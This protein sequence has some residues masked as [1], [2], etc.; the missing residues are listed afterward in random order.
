[1]DVFIPNGTGP[2]WE[3]ELRFA[4]RSLHRYAQVDRVFVF[5]WKPWWLVDVEFVPFPDQGGPANRNTLAK[6]AGAVFHTDIGPQFIHTH[7]DIFLLNDFDPLALHHLPASYARSDVHA[8]AFANAVK[9]VNRPGVRDFERH[10]PVVLDREKVKA[11]IEVLHA[12]NVAFRTAY[13]NLIRAE[14]TPCEDVKLME[15]REP[16][17][18]WPCFSIHPNIG[19]DRR[20]REWCEQRYPDPSPWE[21]L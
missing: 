10:V 8:R 2:L 12:K 6:L 5:G 19:H 14:S 7:D 13:F 11:V 21:W 3:H 1:M 15:W 17:A 16:P 18:S 9:V 4:L 20:F